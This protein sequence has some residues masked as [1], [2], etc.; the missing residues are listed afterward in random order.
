ML[1]EV[2]VPGW[3]WPSSR[4]DGTYLEEGVQVSQGGP[5][6]PGLAGQGTVGIVLVGRYHIDGVVAE[7]AC[8]QGAAQ[9]QVVGGAAIIGS[10][11]QGL[12][13]C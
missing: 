11:G 5:D 7:G 9:S 3:W 8:V 6:L 12:V 13:A 4:V 2:R 1:R 10:G